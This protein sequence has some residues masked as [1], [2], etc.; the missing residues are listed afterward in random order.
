MRIRSWYL[1]LL[2][3]VVTGTSCGITTPEIDAVGTVRFVGLE[4]GCWVI[5]TAQEVYEPLNLPAEM[6]TDGLAVE[7]EAVERDDVA[8]ICMVG[9][10]IEL[11]RIRPAEG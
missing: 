1:A 2:A 5:E 8:S 10:L 9:T 4:G 3:S 7:F 11:L 6:R